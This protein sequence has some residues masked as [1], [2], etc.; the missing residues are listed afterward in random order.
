MGFGVIFTF[1]IN[2]QFLDK[3]LLKLSKR[4][5]DMSNR[6]YTGDMI[7]SLLESRGKTKIDL[8]DA[9]P[10]VSKSQ[11]SEWSRGITK[12]YTKYIGEIAS[13]LDVSVDYLLGNDSN[14]NKPADYTGRPLTEKQKLVW[15]RLMKLSPELLDVA[16]GQID[17][18]LKLQDKTAK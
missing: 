5:F 17:A 16:D 7:F 3:I 9:L 8:A 12:S 1:R 18:L 13:Y 10:G 15:D 4:V 11:V 14:K 6:D 2:T